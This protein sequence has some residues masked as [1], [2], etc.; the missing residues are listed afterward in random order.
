MKYTENLHEAYKVTGFFSDGERRVIR[1]IPFLD[2]TEN[3]V[4]EDMYKTYPDLWW[5]EFDTVFAPES[6]FWKPSDDRK[7]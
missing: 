4:C 5:I 6:S 2:N 1:I 7:G 3:Q